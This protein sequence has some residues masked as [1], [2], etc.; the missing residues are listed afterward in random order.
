MVTLLESKLNSL[1]PEITS[2]YPPLFHCSLN[3]INPEINS[4]NTVVVVSNSTTNINI[5]QENTQNN[6]NKEKEAEVRVNN[7]NSNTEN[8][9]VAVEDNVSTNANPEANAN[10]AANVEP[11][12]ETPE[13]KLKSFIENNPNEDLEGLLKMLKYGIPEQAVLQKARLKGS[14]IETTKVKFIINFLPQ[15]SKKFIIIFNHK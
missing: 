12:E 13:Q 9:T 7:N 8:N 1:P 6:Q 14:D 3:E 5:V 15:F 2:K 4:E 10:Q 11:I